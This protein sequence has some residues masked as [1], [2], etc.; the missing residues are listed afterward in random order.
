MALRVEKPVV[1]NANAQLSKSVGSEIQDSGEC[2]LPSINRYGTSSIVEVLEQA[3]E[4]Y[5]ANPAFTSLGKTL[6]YAE[7]DRQSA[8]FASYLQQSGL[9][10]GDRIAVQLPN[11][12]QYPVV[13]FGAIRAGLVVVNTNPLYTRDEMRHQFRDSGAKA[14]VILANMAN[15]AADVLADTDIRH[16]VVTQIADLHTPV[17]RVVLNSVVR[18]VKRMVP[19]YRIPQAVSL[20]QAL[21]QG[22]K[23]PFE[24]HD[25]QVGDVAVLQYTG[26]T[27]GVAKGA[28]LT[29]GNLLANQLQL[30]EHFGDFL[31]D[32]G[33]EVFIGP[34]PLYHIYAF[35]LHCMLLLGAGNHSVLIPN[36]RDIPGFVKELKKW[37][38]TG[39]AGL[40]TL[41]VAL[42]RDQ[43][44]CEL[45]FSALKFTASGGMA[46]TRDAA[47]RWEEVTGS[48]VLEGYGLTETSPAVTFNR[49]G[50]HQI[51]SI[52]VPVPLT[53]VK[54][55]DDDGVAQEHD[56]PG[57]LCV[58]GPQVMKGYW[59]RPD[60]T[61]E[62]LDDEGW[63]KT[64]DMAVIQ[65]DG[66][67]RIVDRKKDLI[68]V[69]GFNVYPNEIE[70]VVVT[71]PEVTECAAIGVPDDKCGEAV[72]LYVVSDT[73]QLTEEDVRT[74]CRSKLTA[75]KVPRNVLFCDEL[76]KTNVGKV[77]RRAL[78]E[79][80][81]KN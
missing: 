18:Y 29:H 19:K 27:T 4:K 22:S 47:E 14:L 67:L 62:V 72:M 21:K 70:D 24:R 5:A 56:I 74:Y 75:Y 54:V 25:P 48:A 44:F 7:L 81:I 15:L 16:V 51:G 1:M 61:A 57:E 78:K 13:V 60:A 49:P 11:L 79:K 66:Y 28:M 58:R 39:F 41:F 2:Y 17:K 37:R 30:T 32:S 23:L 71:L 77:L 76:P 31:K 43:Q 38:F 42:C 12:I 64:G 63:L 9:K 69:S 20:R 3:C 80:A 73:P 34:L 6:S 59:Q 8:A 65:P 55:L 35:T 45:D 50:E 40:N 46:L 36:P 33:K 53:E 26:G 52:G 10:P 68:I